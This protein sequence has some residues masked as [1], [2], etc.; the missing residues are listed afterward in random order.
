MTTITNST[1]SN[2]Y[3]VLKREL[4]NV[5]FNLKSVNIPNI[6]FGIVEAP[7]MVTKMKLPGESITFDP[8]TFEVYL[9][10]EFQVFTDLYDDLILG[11]DLE[12]GILQPTK[13]TFTLSVIIT[14]NKNNPCLK[15]MFYDAF[16]T[17]FGDI[18]MDLTTESLIMPVTAEYKYYKPI[19]LT[20]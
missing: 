13:K 12:T 4:S 8:L 16:I 14:T 3:V 18:S 9:D 2:F 19:R 20:T 10:N 11:A 6:A 7:W 17:N 15:L 5:Q 1:A